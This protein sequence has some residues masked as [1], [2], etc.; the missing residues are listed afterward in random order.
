MEILISYLGPLIISLLPILIKEDEK[1]HPSYRFILAILV[2][3]LGV[4]IF[5]QNS[6]LLSLSYIV[7][8]IVYFITLLK[9]PSRILQ[10]FLGDSLFCLWQLPSFLV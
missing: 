3:A 7:Y 1:I 10:I 9:K 2:I 8:S 6:M 5:V 4:S